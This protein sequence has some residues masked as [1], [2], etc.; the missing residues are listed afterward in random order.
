V[1]IACEDA[2]AYAAW[3]GQRLPTE[4]EWE[5]A[6]RGG[7]DG[8]E[9]TWGDDPEPATE[10]RAI[11][12][13]GDFPWRAIRGYGSTAPV[14]SFPANAYGLYDMAGNVWEFMADAWGPYPSVPQSDPLAGGEPLKGDGY[15]SVKGRRVIRGGSWGGAPLNLRVAYRDSHPADGARDFVGFRCAASPPSKGLSVKGQ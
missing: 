9:Y 1:H 15:L 13:H 10:R 5:F 2:E 8:A 12:W 7:L 11:Y 4:A 14:G 3:A 6:A